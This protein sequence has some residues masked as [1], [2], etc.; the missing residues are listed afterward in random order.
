MPSLFQE[1]DLITEAGHAITSPVPASS[2]NFDGRYSAVY[3]LATVDLAV[4]AAIDPIENMP[5]PI[6]LP[7]FHGPM[8]AR[9]Y[10][11]GAGPDWG[12]TR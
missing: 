11:L 6:R 4:P 8:V 10:H 9:K 7:S 2:E 1:V 12:W 3:A 5:V